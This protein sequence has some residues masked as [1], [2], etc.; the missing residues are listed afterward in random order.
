LE[1]Y[2]EN[3]ITMKGQAETKRNAQVPIY[4]ITSDGF[5]Q[6]E[7]NELI[8]GVSNI[9]CVM[10][11]GIVCG[12]LIRNDAVPTDIRVVIKNGSQLYHS[13]IH[14]KKV[15]D[16]SIIHVKSH[17][18]DE[19]KNTLVIAD[20]KGLSLCDKK[21]NPIGE[22]YE[23]SFRIV[24]EAEGLVL[25]NELPMETY[26]KYVLPSEM[27]RS[28]G[29]EALKAQAV[30]ARTY[31]YA[32]MKNQSYA[33]YGA[34]LDDSTNFQAY[35]NL[36]R[37]PET[38]A[39]VDATT[40]EVITCN[41]ALISCYY[42]STSPGVTNDMSSWENDSNKDYI[43]CMGM[44]FSDG[45]NLR[46]ASDFTQF[47]TSEN[48]C[49][50]AGSSFFR[51]KA[52]LN[53]SNVLESEKGRLKHLEV[54]QRNQAG[55][56]TELLL[57][58]ENETVILKNEN[59]IRKVLGDYLEE[60]ILQNE[61]V[62][63]DLT[64]VPSACFEILNIE[65]EKVLLRGG[66]FGHGIGM[67]QY[68]AHAMAEEGFTYWR[69]SIYADPHYTSLTENMKKQTTGRETVLSV[70]AGKVGKTIPIYQHN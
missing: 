1:S 40:G 21:G 61:Q 70:S 29:E 59:E 19:N 39:A 35:H 44:E 48:D 28:F 9:Q 3:S 18:N 41:G 53:T 63:T 57:T 8:I 26:V 23:G 31:A 60:V 51:W 7:W 17:M 50:D 55:Y 58:Y 67:S 62:R 32:H 68:G 25:I 15:S 12:I 14:V 10:E 34:N 24:K 49:Y 65:D 64:M 66:G 2:T 42:Y 43:A 27:L 54:R 37:Y 33:K 69:Y 56:I 47:M 11:R 20:E 36:G 22:A 45:L 13:D 52:I 46:E 16:A 38:D 5:E 6:I 4:K 30:C